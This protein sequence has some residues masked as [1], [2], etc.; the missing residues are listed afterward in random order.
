M[1]E[2][3][4]RETGLEAGDANDVSRSYPKASSSNHPKVRDHAEAI[5]IIPVPVANASD[6]ADLSS[7]RAKFRGA[8][9][10]RWRQRFDPPCP[11]NNYFVFLRFI[12]LTYERCADRVIV[13]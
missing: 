1:P 10:R 4:I 3:M 2:E 11:G 6:F 13:L 8:G 9:S 12:L 7:M 5:C